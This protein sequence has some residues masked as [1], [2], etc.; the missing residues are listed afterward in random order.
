MKLD[1]PP[2]SPIKTTLLINL[3]TIDQTL[4]NNLKQANHTS[5]PKRKLGVTAIV[6][7][8][9]SGPE[10]RPKVKANENKYSKPKTRSKEKVPKGKNIPDL[11]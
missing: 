3:D 2:S 4:N 7:R 10:V 5:L 11:T 9:R 6:A 8:I 1:I